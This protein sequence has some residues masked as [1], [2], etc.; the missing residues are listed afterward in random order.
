MNLCHISIH[1]EKK[2]KKSG[3]KRKLGKKEKE[4]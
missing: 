4:V 1:M 3:K 2:S